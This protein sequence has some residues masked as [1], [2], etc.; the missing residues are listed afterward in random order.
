VNTPDPHVPLAPTAPSRLE[1]LFPTLTH[2]QMARIAA[3]G[4]R[5]PI[6]RGKILVELGDKD[7]PFFVGSVAPSATQVSAATVRSAIWRL[8]LR[9]S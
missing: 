6:A 1:R 8:A 2:T 9:S 3:R 4:R 5:R 7:V